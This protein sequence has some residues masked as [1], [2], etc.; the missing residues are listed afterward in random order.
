MIE[1]ENL[2]E[3]TG[4]LEVI[5]SLLFKVKLNFNTWPPLR[6]ARGARRTQTPFNDQPYNR[7]SDNV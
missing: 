6:E 2:S 3:N 4:L 7:T 1:V 5:W